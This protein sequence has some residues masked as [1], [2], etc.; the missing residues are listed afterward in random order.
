MTPAVHYNVT[1]NYHAYSANEETIHPHD[2][3]VRWFFGMNFG[4][5]YLF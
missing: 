4:L 3:P 2:S 5:G 1:G